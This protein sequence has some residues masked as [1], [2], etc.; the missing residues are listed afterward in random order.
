MNKR[1]PD[2]NLCERAQKVMNHDFPHQILVLMKLLTEKD[3]SGIPRTKSIEFCLADFE[4]LGFYHPDRFL[5]ANAENKEKRSQYTI[6]ITEMNR[7]NYVPFL[8]ISWV[9]IVYSSGEES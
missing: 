1:Y 8:C 2:L 6:I 3:E 4:M 9:Y 7:Q 5:S